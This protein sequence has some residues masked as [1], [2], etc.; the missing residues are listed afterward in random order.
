MP[1]TGKD[2]LQRDISLYLDSKVGV[3]NRFQTERRT[4]DNSAPGSTMATKG[5][6]E[7][8]SVIRNC[9]CPPCDPRVR[10]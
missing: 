2:I 6:P 3:A 10:E 9:L 7:I 4:I 1:T 5:S 8:R